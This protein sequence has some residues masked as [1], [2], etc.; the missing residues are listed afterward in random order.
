MASNNLFIYIFGGYRESSKWD[1]MYSS[2]MIEQSLQPI[3]LWSWVNW[4]IPYQ[5]RDN[6]I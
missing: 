4:N 5:T 3:L 6:K 2:I 1:V